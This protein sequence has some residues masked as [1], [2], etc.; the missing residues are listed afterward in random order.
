[1]KTIYETAVGGDG[2][3][4]G[5]YLSDDGFIVEQVKYP[6]GKAAK[7]AHDFV[8]KAVDGLEAKIPGEWDK[9]VLEPARVAAHGAIDKLI[10]AV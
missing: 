9:V 3:V 5:L 7:P 1:M 10:G 2:A 6:I 4:F 8:D